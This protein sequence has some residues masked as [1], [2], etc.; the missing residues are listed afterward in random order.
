VSVTF[1]T[2]TTI[3]YAVSGKDY[4]T[5]LLRF[6]QTLGS[7]DKSEAVLQRLRYPVGTVV[8]VS[9]DPSRPGVAVMKP[10]LHTDA[11]WLPGAGLSIL[12]PAVLGLL[13]LPA[14]FRDF[15]VENKD[16]ENYVERSIQEGRSDLPEPEFRQ[17]GDKVM[18]VVA[19]AF[20]AAFCCLGLLALTAGVERMWHG[21]A[22]RSWPTVAGVVTATGTDEP[23]DTTD[24]AYRARMI[25]QYEVNGAVHFNNLRR[26]AQVD[27]EAVY[28]TGQHVK[29]S[30]FPGDPDIAVVEPGNTGASMVVP[31][32]G[33]V[34]LLFSLAVFYVVVPALGKG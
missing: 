25:Y 2:T 10:G 26:F 3:R 15:T 9:Y 6:G 31:A 19:A 8:P 4:T 18:P 29:V 33:A 11:F 7:G 13:L 22:S 16:F 28:K 5:A 27:S 20:G 21:A 34:L 14:F 1:G 30:Y 24:S 32:I 23:N 17:P 12:L